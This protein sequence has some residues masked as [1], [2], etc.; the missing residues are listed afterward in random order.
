MPREGLLEGSEWKSKARL[1][2]QALASFV[3]A[4]FFLMLGSQW[5]NHFYS[6]TRTFAWE[7]HERGFLRELLRIDV[8]SSEG[9]AAICYSTAGMVYSYSCPFICFVFPFAHSSL[10]INKI[11]SLGD[12]SQTSWLA[13][14]GGNGASLRGGKVGDGKKKRH[15]TPSIHTQGLGT[16][17]AHK[18]GDLSLTTSSVWWCN[19]RTVRL[20]LT[21]TWGLLTS[22]SSRTGEFPVH[23]NTLSQKKKKI[24]KAEW[25]MTIPGIALWLLHAYTC[26]C[27]HTWVHA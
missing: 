23:W 1:S 13:R 8:F 17:I 16:W 26:T 27:I 14:A 7:K 24:N 4:L 5:W 11:L 19:H 6:V 18:L 12:G 3:L 22:Q 25:L 2:N 15:F 21:N 20:G 10:T 9:P